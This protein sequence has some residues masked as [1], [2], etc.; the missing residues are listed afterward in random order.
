MYSTG[1]GRYHPKLVER[2]FEAYPTAS[3]DERQ[4]GRFGIALK[5]LDA[6]AETARVARTFDVL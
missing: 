6:F 5:P 1:G 2:L 4:L 3:W